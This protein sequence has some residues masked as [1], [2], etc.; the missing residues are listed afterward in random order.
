MRLSCGYLECPEDFLQMNM[1]QIAEL[2]ARGR[3]ALKLLLSNPTERGGSKR[4]L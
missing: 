3:S 1:V 2:S 4:R